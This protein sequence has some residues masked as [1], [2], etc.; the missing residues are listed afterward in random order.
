MPHSVL[1]GD[2]LLVIMK[3]DHIFLRLCFLGLATL[4][5]GLVLVQLHARSGGLSLGT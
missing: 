3:S 5:G 2:I 1:L 4:D